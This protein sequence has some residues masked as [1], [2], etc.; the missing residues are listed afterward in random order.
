MDLKTRV[1][2]EKDLDPVWEVYLATIAAQ[3]PEH[4]DPYWDAGL[5]PTHESIAGHLAAGELCVAELDGRI[6]GAMALAHREDDDLIGF[7][8]AMPAE[9]DQVACVHLLT[10]DPAVR[11]RGV[12]SALIAYATDLAREW[13]KVAVHLDVTRDNVGAQAMYAKAGFVPAGTRSFVREDGQELGFVVME[14]SL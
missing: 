5:H 7:D 11:G 12:G 1:A 10:C 3:T 9:P 2:T 6:V 8:F 14:A 4:P 13:G